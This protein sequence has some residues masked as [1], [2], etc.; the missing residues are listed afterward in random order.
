MSGHLSWGRMPS[1]ALWNGWV[2]GWREP[3]LEAPGVQAE[4]LERLST[5]VMQGH[6]LGKGKHLKRGCLYFPGA[7]SLAPNKG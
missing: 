2:A 6:G 5:S 3:G 1:S 4:F 7:N